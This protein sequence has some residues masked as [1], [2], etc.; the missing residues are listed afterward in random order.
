MHRTTFVFL[1]VILIGAF[2]M[3]GCTSPA[4]VPTEIPIPPTATS[5]ITPEPTI[6][7]TAIPSIPVYGPVNYPAGM[8]PLTGLQ[9]DDPLLLNRCPMIIKVSNY[10]RS[11]RP[12][13]GLSQADLVFDYYI[14]EGMNRFAVV[15][16]GQDALKVGPIR[17][18]R[19]VDAQLATMY[20]GILAFKGAW[21]KVNEVLYATLKKRAISGSPSTCPGICDTGNETVISMFANT[22][23]LSKYVADKGYCDASQLDLA[24][25]V[26]SEEL[27]RD[28]RPAPD[29]SVIFSYY[30][31]GEWHYDE[32]TGLYLRWIESVAGEEGEEIIT[33][34]PLTDANSGEQ[35]GFENVA[36][37]F[38]Q[39]DMYAPTYFD[40][41]LGGNTSGA[42]LVLLR[43]GKAFDGIW[44]SAGEDKPL[45]FF[46]PEGGYLAFKPG[47]TWLVLVGSKSI[48]TTP[49]GEIWELTNH[50]P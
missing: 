36:I 14:G 38:A 10:P 7:T 26:F 13:A 12:H 47:K 44:K 49:P 16:Y 32:S 17:S 4:V 19:L 48:L 29:L 30:N 35:L 11:G 25:M 41:Q 34:V 31:R 6:E 27:P 5:G 3:A 28:G 8:D 42:R 24:G 18:G 46:T 33:M 37:L 2:L 45:Q 21:Y 15:Y 1:G 20:Q 23:E 40:I 39:H 43:D 9:V 22:A 50:L